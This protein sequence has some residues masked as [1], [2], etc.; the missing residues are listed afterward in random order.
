MAFEDRDHMQGIEG[1]EVTPI[2]GVDADHQFAFSGVLNHLLHDV[3]AQRITRW[4]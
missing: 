2:A 4:Q 1:A 3:V